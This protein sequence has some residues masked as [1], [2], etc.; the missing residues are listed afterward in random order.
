M[1]VPPSPT[2]S[3]LAR[4]ILIPRAQRVSRAR[5]ATAAMPPC[6]PYITHTYAKTHLAHSTVSFP[7]SMR[8]KTATALNVHQARPKTRR[9][10][11]RVGAQISCGRTTGAAPGAIH[12]GRSAI[13]NTNGCVMSV[14]KLRADCNLVASLPERGVPPLQITALRTGRSRRGRIDSP[15]RS[16]PP[17]RSEPRAAIPP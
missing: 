13:R 16:R 1:Y 9:A 8:S 17:R 14:M 3:P 15:T 6:H 11:P 5:G 7:Q 4:S 2:V 10:H 12:C